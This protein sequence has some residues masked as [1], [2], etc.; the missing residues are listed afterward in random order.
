MDQPKTELLQTLGTD[1][2]EGVLV[3]IKIFR[4]VHLMAGSSGRME[5][6]KKRLKNEYKC[7]AMLPDHPNVLKF[8]GVLLPFRDFELASPGLVSV[9]HQEGNL[10][11][12]LGRRSI[13]GEPIQRLS[14]LQDVIAG[15]VFLHERD[16]VHGD[17]TI[18][19]ILVDRDERGNYR[20]LVSDM[21][22]SRVLDQDGYTTNI[23]GHPSRF[24]PPEVIE[25]DTDDL[26]VTNKFY[27]TK[28]SDVYS[29]SLIM[30][31]VLSGKVP[32]S[33]ERWKRESALEVQIR[34]GLRPHPAKYP[35]LD[36][37]HDFCWKIM[38]ECWERNP[39]ERISSARVQEMLRS[40]GPNGKN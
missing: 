37:G 22:R 13:T 28:A 21:S 35:F 26:E 15:L 11:E 40:G 4:G 39:A 7:W 27:L 10:F 3:A 32:F 34:Q 5:E 23:G 14:L 17:L 6:Y 18:R 19:N 9:Y 30:L 29:Y 8:Q 24:N 31:E 12:F 1:C 36:C 25:A 33:Q 2:F 16:V 20:A 38:K